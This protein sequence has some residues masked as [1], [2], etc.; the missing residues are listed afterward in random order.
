MRSFSLSLLLLILP[1]SCIGVNTAQ[2]QVQLVP[3]SVGS[4]PNRP[5]NK[6]LGTKDVDYAIVNKDYAKAAGIL[7]RLNDLPPPTFRKYLNVIKEGLGDLFLETLEND[8]TLDALP[9]Y[10]SLQ[11]LG[12]ADLYISGS[13]FTG[14]LF[15]Y[16]IRKEY[17]GAA[18]SFAQ[19]SLQNNIRLDDE[20]N[21]KLRV[22]IR[23]QFENN[24]D[25]NNVNFWQQRIDGTV[26]IFVKMGTERL[27]H[28]QLYLPSTEIGSGFFIDNSGSIIT[29]YHVIS[30]QTGKHR[31][32][33]Q[34]FVKLS[35]RDELIP[36]KLV[37]WDPNRDLALLRIS[38]PSPYLLRM[39]STFNLIQYNGEDRQPNPALFVGSELYAIGAPGG[40]EN[41]LTSGRVSARGR[42][43][44]PLTEAL[45]IDVPANPGNSGGPLLNSKGIVEGVVFAKNNSGYEG[46][47]FA[48][49]SDTLGSVIPR[50]YL[51]G[52]TGNS[53][54]GL[55][56]DEYSNSKDYLEIRYIFPN[57]PAAMSFLKPG[58]RII[59]YRNDAYTKINT[60]RNRISNG[61][62]GALVNLT[63]QDP[64]DGTT[65]E[66]FLELSSRPDKPMHQNL[67]QESTIKLFYAL[68]GARLQAATGRRNMYE[69]V[70]TLPYSRVSQLNL[71]R[72][73]YVRIMQW[74]IDTDRTTIIAHISY[75][76]KDGPE[77]DN[78]KQS[79]L[80]QQIDLPNI[81]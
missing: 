2:D 53:W 51:G 50:L 9:Y 24:P 62:T 6:N 63:V 16:Y 19:A 68:F 39:N 44:L 26:T 33:G 12:A 10:Y 41:T 54:L 73:D 4:A 70:S 58:M 18:L 8:G 30:S 61:P 28:T 11:S 40:L 5:F 7:S 20:V 34:I 60:L 43:I 66:V 56:V 55:V 59:S 49:P 64:E 77:R 52:K 42:E 69:I 46:I 74:L 75:S 31:D 13:E 37:G 35:S 47:A 65:K 23:E 72:G 21:T 48:I 57:S 22:F 81:L 15:D 36:A 80:I 1:V 14:R 25:N 3:V 78:N 76:Y 27:P 71:N 38:R 45:Q 17:F 29:N 79:V 32:A 67:G